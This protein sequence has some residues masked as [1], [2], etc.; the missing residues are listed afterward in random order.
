[1]TSKTS[2][3]FVG[4]G[5]MGGAMAA[6]LIEKGADLTV[7]NRTP[8]RIAPLA[9]LGAHQ[10]DSL[11]DVA[12]GCEVV[13]SIVSDDEAALSI[14]TEP[15]GLLDGARRGQLFID[16]STLRPETVLQIAGQ[17][18]KLGA[19]FLDSPVAGTIAP[20]R[21]GQLVALVGGKR[22]DLERAKPVLNLMCR[23]IIHAGDQG[24]GALLK[25][26]VN[27]PLGVYWQALTEAIALGHEGG[28]SMNLMLDTISASGA[29]L[30]AL[31]AQ[32]PTILD[33]DAGNN[34][35][36]ETMRKDLTYVV[37]A[38]TNAGIATPAAAAA[39]ATYHKAVDAGYA[40]DDAVAIVTHFSQM[41]GHG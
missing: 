15:G 11:H 23:R 21:Q 28:L 24:Q 9:A 5:K 33:P 37:G 13:I 38:A 26:V 10:A 36:V 1:M 22:E 2:L 12:G 17:A 3:G 14:Y 30:A 35:D 39:L 4:L 32:I 7:W 29:C 25:L 18:R 6:R 41:L 34:F 8:K 31:P 19:S 27:L 20:A 40:K 16:M